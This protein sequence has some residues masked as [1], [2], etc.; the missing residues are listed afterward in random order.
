MPD[1]MLRRVATTA[2]LTQG[3]LIG[4][5]GLAFAVTLE[6]PWRDNQRRVSHIP[7][8]RSYTCRRVDSPGFGDTFEITGVPNRDKVLFHGGN[9]PADT[10][11]CVLV[12][13]G[14]DLVKGEHGIVQSQ[15]EF[16]EFLAI[17]QGVEEFTL[18]VVSA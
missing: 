8:G 15:K 7:G 6:L 1:L 10:E 2:K 3:V 5:G 4:P 11:G 17:Q 9:T 13:H 14:F 18:H 16:R 12:G